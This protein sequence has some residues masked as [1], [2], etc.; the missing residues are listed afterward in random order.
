MTG[1]DEMTGDRSTIQAFYSVMRPY[2]PG[3][4]RCV[5]NGVVMDKEYP[6]I[7]DHLPGEF[8]GLHPT[9]KR[10]NVAAIRQYVS[11]SDTV[12]VVGA[13][14]GVTTVVAARQAWR[15][16]VHAYEPGSEWIE[17]TKGTVRLN[18]VEDRVTLVETS[19]GDVVTSQG[20][21]TSAADE[22]DPGELPECDVM[23]LDCEGAETEI[24]SDLGTLPHVI[25]VETH[26]FRGAPTGATVTALEDHGYGIAERMPVERGEKYANEHD[27]YVLVATRSDESHGRECRT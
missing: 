1:P 2:I 4:K 5:Y 16:T 17:L 26:G 13:G 24:I 21:D 9:Y 3:T 14:Q 25:V 18:A 27:A 8:S 11:P 10:P 19:V 6:F 20:S 22:R 23:E 15:G 12:V 7:E